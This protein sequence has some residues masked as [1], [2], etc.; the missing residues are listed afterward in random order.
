MKIIELINIEKKKLIENNIE[1][2]TLI[3]RI[4]MQ[5]VLNIDRNKLIIK[6]E[7]DIDSVKKQEYEKYIE[8][9]LEGM[10]LQYITNTQEFM[11]NSFYVN[12]NVLIPQPDTEILVQE[13][14]D[15]I[16]KENKNKILDMCTGSG[17][18][19]ISIA[20]YAENLDITVSDISKEAL[21]V[22]EKNVERNNVK[23]KIVKSDLFENIK[24]KYDIIVSNPPY[25]ETDI[26]KTLSK[27]VQKEP[28]L[29]LDGGKDGLVF[30]RKIINE[31]TKFLNKDG[32]LCLEIGYNQK[33]KVVDIFQKEK[34]FTDI[35]CIKD[36]SEND[37]VIIARYKGGN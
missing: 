24:E 2:A 4:L 29:A 35:K 11:K 20:K 10:P 15:I 37:R 33:E 9:I 8:Q 5:F 17:I 1:D 7:E 23:L 28:K 12:E 18:I 34:E 27:E 16:Q 32:Y 26:I 22:V 3:A 36:L 14:L 30:Y 25:I 21:K 6:Q 13:I 19:G 31:A